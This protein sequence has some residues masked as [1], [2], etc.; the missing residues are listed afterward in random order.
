MDPLS[1]DFARLWYVLVLVSFPLLCRRDVP[2]YKEQDML[3]VAIAYLLVQNQ[4]FKSHRLGGSRFAITFHFSKKKL[5][6]KTVPPISFYTVC[7][8]TGLC[9][10]V[11]CLLQQG[12]VVIVVVG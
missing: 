9:G 10:G 7:F 2:W 1:V 4:E 6:H 11:C 3:S 5:C 12:L 8:M